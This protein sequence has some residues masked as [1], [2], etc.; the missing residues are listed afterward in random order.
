MV[1]S[2]VLQA[3]EYTLKHKPFPVMKAIF[4]SS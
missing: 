2:H 3:F 1:A 4:K